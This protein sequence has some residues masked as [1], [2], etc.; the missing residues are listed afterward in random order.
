MATQNRLDPD[1]DHR[2]AEYRACLAGP[3]RPDHVAELRRLGLP[4][5]ATQGEASAA[6]TGYYVAM[7][8]CVE[9]GR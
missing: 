9:V 5:P 4:V 3:P 6:L 2:A 7:A 1:P 8:R